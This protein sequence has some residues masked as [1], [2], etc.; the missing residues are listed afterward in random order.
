MDLV[1][2]PGLGEVPP[3]NGVFT[4]QVRETQ[5]DRVEAWTANVS[6][7]CFFVVRNQNLDSDQTAQMSV[8]HEFSLHSQDISSDLPG[9]VLKILQNHQSVVFWVE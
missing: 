4:K 7:T 6:H 5:A 3:K 8:D 2:V 1:G 9:K